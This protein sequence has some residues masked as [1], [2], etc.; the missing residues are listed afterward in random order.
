MNSAGV[1]GVTESRLPGRRMS[2]SL[3]A[4]HSRRSGRLTRRRKPWW[5]DTSRQLQRGFAFVDLASK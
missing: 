1:T 5:N 4:G 3:R 2:I